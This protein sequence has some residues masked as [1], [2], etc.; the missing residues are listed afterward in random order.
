MTANTYVLARALGATWGPGDEV[1][2]SRLDHDANIRPWVLAAA[3][4][5]ATVRWVD[6]DVATD[7]H[8]ESYDDVLT[9]R[10]RLVAVTAASNATGARP[11]LAAIAAKAHAVGALVHVDGVHATPHAP[12]AWDAAGADCSFP[13]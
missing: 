5:G 2:V 6:P 8:P 3:R 9:D 1:V 4:A 10:T 12:V 11:D 7:L 13:S